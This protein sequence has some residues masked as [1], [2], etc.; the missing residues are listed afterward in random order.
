MKDRI[1]CLLL[2]IQYPAYSAVFYNV[3]KG[4][5]WHCMLSSGRNEASSGFEGSPINMTRIGHLRPCRTRRFS[6]VLVKISPYMFH[7]AVYDAEEALNG[8]HNTLSGGTSSCLCSLSE[9]ASWCMSLILIMTNI[10]APGNSRLI[11][12]ITS[13]PEGRSSQQLTYRGHSN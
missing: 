8:I 4:C 10:H 7:R 9:I 13:P 6:I 11:P 12:T 3:L 2:K 5:W 1:W